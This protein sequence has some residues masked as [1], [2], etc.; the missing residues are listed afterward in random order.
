MKLQLELYTLYHSLTK[1]ATISNLT[2]TEVPILN[3]N[4]AKIDTE[5]K[6]ATGTGYLC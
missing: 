5:S 3:I 2:S 1:Y 6:H 4:Y